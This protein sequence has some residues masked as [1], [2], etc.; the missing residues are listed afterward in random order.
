MLAVGYGVENGDEYFL[1]K[2]SWGPSWGDQGYIKL[3]VDNV[4]GILMQPV[5]PNAVA[6]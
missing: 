4:C 5:M 6:V 3:G 2:N 1:V